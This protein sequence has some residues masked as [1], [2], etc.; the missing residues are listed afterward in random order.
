MPYDHLNYNLNV[1]FTFSPLDSYGLN[2]NVQMLLFVVLYD[3]YSV[4]YK[5]MHAYIQYTANYFHYAIWIDSLSLSGSF[6]L[7]LISVF[8]KSF[9]FGFAAFLATLWTFAFLDCM[10]TSEWTLPHTT[11]SAY[12]TNRNK[13]VE[14]RVFIS[15]FHLNW[16]HSPNNVIGNID[17][18]FSEI[19]TKFNIYSIIGVHL[20]KQTRKRKNKQSH[21]FVYIL[22]ERTF[23]QEKGV[24]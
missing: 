11:S 10:T 21:A 3:F 13:I 17:Y 16:R 22:A 12:L 19:S 5:Y 6:L 8:S 1:H 9:I 23:Q 4:I 24:F 2:L 15:N 18:V 7:I 14:K 20:P